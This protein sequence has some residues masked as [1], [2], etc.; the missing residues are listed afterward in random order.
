MKIRHDVC[1]KLVQNWP[2]LSTYLGPVRAP[3]E[4]WYEIDTTLERLV[5]LALYLYIYVY[6]YRPSCEIDDNSDG[7]DDDDASDAD[8]A[9]DTDDNTDDDSYNV[10][11]EADGDEE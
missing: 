6:I 3:Y 8:T 9:D 2:E 1:A 4:N 5:V 10:Y 7:D 11:D